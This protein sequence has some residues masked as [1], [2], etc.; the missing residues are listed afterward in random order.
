MKRVLIIEDDRSIAELERDYLQAGG[1]EAVVAE[2]GKTG[3]AHA[4]EEHF[5]LIVLD[6]MLPGMDGFEVCRKIRT[7]KEVPVLIVSA[8]RDDADKVKG[9]GIGAD[10]YIVK[11]FSPSEL[12]ARVRAHIARFERLTNRNGKREIRVRGLVIDVPARRVYVQD[13][14]AVLKNKEFELLLFLAENPNIVF[15]K[16][17]LFDRIWGMDSL[18]D[19]ATVT[20]HINRIRDKI[21]ETDKYIETVWGS[22]Y[23]FRA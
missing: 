12:V 9:L 2:N 21:E 5:D 17:T 19:T 8:R 22:G 4:L 6:V 3:L 20:V 11:P 15:S 7:R 18:G 10:D 1:F 13:K 14:E 16:E 23:R